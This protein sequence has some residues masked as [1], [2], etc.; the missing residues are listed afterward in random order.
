MNIMGMHCIIAK[1]HY[2]VFILGSNGETLAKTNHIASLVFLGDQL[3]VF[4]QH[5][6]VCLI[7]RKR[8]NP[9]AVHNSRLGSSNQVY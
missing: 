5:I 2:E 7:C 1:N 6:F 8:M 9:E 3:L 4:T